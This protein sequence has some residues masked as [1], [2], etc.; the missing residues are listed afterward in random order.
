VRNDP[1][2][3]VT[4]AALAA[5]HALQMQLTGRMR[6]AFAAQQQVTTLRASLAEA[7]TRATGDAASA[8]ATLRAAIDSAAGTGQRAV[9]R[10]ITG[11]LAGQLAAQD[12]AD[13]A[14]N[15]AMLAAF[16][17]TSTRLAAAEVRW[18]RI[19]E[20][21]LATLNATR[22]RLGLSAVRVQ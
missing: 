5:Q 18:S 3:R 17:A 19:V 14:P 1:R 8:I 13:N 22:A 7:S 12:N 11:E 2:V 10:D 16:T 9:F 6:A 15:A 21:D 4:P 20:R